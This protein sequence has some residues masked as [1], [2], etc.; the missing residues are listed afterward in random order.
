MLQ[1]TLLDSKHIFWE[2]E[3]NFMPQT[4]SSASSERVVL[5]KFCHPSENSDLVFTLGSCEEQSWGYAE[6]RVSGKAVGSKKR[7]E[8]EKKTFLLSSLRKESI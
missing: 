7:E 2:K 6:P 4:V 1:N 8:E 3:I 5:Y